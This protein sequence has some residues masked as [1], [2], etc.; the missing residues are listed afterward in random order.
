MLLQ[1]LKFRSD[2]IKVGN[3]LTPSVR[4]PVLPIFHQVTLNDESYPNPAESPGKSQFAEKEGNC[5]IQQGRRNAGTKS[6]EKEQLASAEFILKWFTEEQ[7]NI[8]F[9]TASGYLQ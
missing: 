1:T 4:L 8:A 9:S 6:D 2:D 3:I 7:Q 5:Q